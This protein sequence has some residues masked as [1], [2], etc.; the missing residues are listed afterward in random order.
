MGRRMS[1]AT[2]AAELARL[3]GMEAAELRPVFSARLGS[4]APATA[5]GRLLRIALAHELQLKAHGREAPRV[6]K[7]YARIGVALAA[8][9]DPEQAMT[10][11][12]CATPIRLT[13]EGGAEDGGGLMKNK[14][15]GDGSQCRRRCAIYTRKST[16]EGL[17][18]DV[19]SLGAQREVCE[20]LI[21]SKRHEGWV[22]LPESYDDGGFSGG[23]MERPELKR[24]LA[25]L[26]AGRIDVVVVYKVSPVSALGPS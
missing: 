15:S 17:D 21:A 25:N 9:C 14:P 13:R 2:L 24:L 5:S 6:A 26:E 10:G 20:A 3:E 8:G 1:E 18:Q 4:P 12:T 11:S 22:M 19:N 23:S 7:A 16:E